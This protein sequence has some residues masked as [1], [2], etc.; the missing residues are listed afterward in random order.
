MNDFKVS[1]IIVAGGSGTRM[2][3]PKQMLDIAGKPALARTVEAFKKVKNITEIIVVSAPETA[4]EIKKIFPEIKTV[5]PGATRLGSVIS[6]VEAVDKNADVISVHDGARPLVNPEKVDLALKTAYDKGASVLAVPVKD[7]IKECSNGVVCKTLDRGVLYAAQTPQSYRADVLKNA[8]E[9]YGKELNA[10]D[11]SQLV[12]KTGVKVNI[13]E[14]D[15]KN[16]K[17]TT[18]EDLIMAEAL[19]KEDKETI[20]RTGIGFDLHRLVEGRKLFIGGLE[21][22]HTK[23]FLGHSDG[24]VVL[25]AVCDAALGA[26]CAG[27]IGVYYPPTDAKIEGIS[28]VDIAKK[29]IEILKEKNARIVHID[30]VIITEEPKMKPHY[31]AIRE[32]LGKVFNM[33]VDS[34]SFKSKSHEKLGDIGAGNAAM[35]QC[36]VTVK[37]ER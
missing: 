13:V 25:H 4:A 23:G 14:S 34:I 7:T 6:G 24:D 5:A 32:S 16:I 12:E 19:V 10:T 15:Y 35:C 22:P 20:Y 29:V 18:P 30:A 37:T 26:V 8:L 31:Q 27:E 17:I 3:R 21:I 33:G 1:A 2:G 36:V 9:K 11:E 28:S